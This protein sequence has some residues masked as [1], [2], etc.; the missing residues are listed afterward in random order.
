MK[1]VS[2]NINGLRA[3]LGKGFEDIFREMDA[4]CFCLQET[5][6][7]PGQVELALDGYESYFDYAKKKGYSGTAIITRIKPL[8]ESKGIGIE[9]HDQEGRVVTLDLGPAYLV[10]VYTPNSQ[11]KLRRIDY[12]LQWEKAFAD[13]V[14]AL[15]A[16]KPVIIC[17]D[18]NVAHTEID[19][20]NPRTN[21]GNPGFSD[22]E[23]G[24]FSELLHCGFTDTFRHLHPDRKDAY[25]WW[26][27]WYK[28]RERNKGWRIDYFL[29]SDRIKH[30]V[31]AAEIHPDIMGSDHCPVSLEIDL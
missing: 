25:T 28:A 17:G 2:W 7:Q 3:I 21:R 9:D 22:G 1:L 5:K 14:C 30:L 13:Y 10:N 20:A 4:D 6:I 15:D 8:S 29:V 11:E 31:T 23:R 27:F 12:R 26:S 16:K 19:L 24:A 18:M